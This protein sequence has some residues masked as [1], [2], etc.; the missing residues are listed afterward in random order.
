MKINRRAVA[1]AFIGTAMISAAICGIQLIKHKSRKIK[2]NTVEKISLPQISEDKKEAIESDNIVSESSIA[3]ELNNLKN[4]DKIE[5]VC[6]NNEISFEEYIINTYYQYE[7]SL[8]GRKHIGTYFQNK[9]KEMNV[10]QKQ[11][12]KELDSSSYTLSNFENGKYI[13]SMNKMKILEMVAEYTDF[14]SLD[15][16][17]VL[18]VLTEAFSE[19]IA[20]EALPTAVS[21]IEVMP[22]YHINKVSFD[23]FTTPEVASDRNEL[24]KLLLFYS[25]NKEYMKS[26]RIWSPF[27]YNGTCIMP[28]SEKSESRNLTAQRIQKN[29][30]NIN[31]NYA[32]QYTYTNL[33]IELNNP[34]DSEDIFSDIL[35]ALQEIIQDSPLEIFVM[36]SHIKELLKNKKS[37]KP[38][39]YHILLA[40]LAKDRAVTS[41]AVQKLTDSLSEK[42]GIQATTIGKDNKE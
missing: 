6:K 32:F 42:F 15:E 8:E 12:A 36:A 20:S 30:Y 9:R 21:K 34:D 24:R 17:E 41:S 3:V 28:F 25:G 5:N 31:G 7:L 2:M 1:L 38:A 29:F 39:H 4:D 18:D 10:L 23:K 40:H 22:F 35:S 16:F 27:Y 26:N 37:Y 13:S 11:L 33:M 19:S 14:L